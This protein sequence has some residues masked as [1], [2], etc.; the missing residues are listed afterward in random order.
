MPC[1]CEQQRSLDYHLASPQQAWRACALQ[2][3]VSDLRGGL[4][5]DKAKQQPTT[6][7]MDP[8]QCGCRG[9]PAAQAIWTLLCQGS[10]LTCVAVRSLTYDLVV[11]K[12]RLHQRAQHSSGSSHT[13]KMRARHKHRCGCWCSGLKTQDRGCCRTA[14][15]AGQCDLPESDHCLASL[16]SLHSSQEQVWPGK[17]AIFFCA[18]AVSRMAGL[19]YNRPC[20]RFVWSQ[21]CHMRKHCPIIEWQVPLSPDP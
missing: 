2:A 16:S 11:R 1:T 5:Q 19:G 3:S 18:C 7:C 13:S 17:P 20:C 9:G 21:T 8:D 6:V 14:A 4:H 15:A 12:Q 10:H